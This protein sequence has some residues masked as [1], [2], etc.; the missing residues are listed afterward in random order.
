MKRIAQVDDPGVC[1]QD[2]RP[3]REQINLKMLE[4]GFD[5]EASAF[6]PKGLY[7]W[8]QNDHRVWPIYKLTTISP[9]LVQLLH[10]PQ[11][12]RFC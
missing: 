1:G 3:P 10:K 9:W 7:W 8:L 6:C 12:G 2:P 4:K 11:Q 5:E